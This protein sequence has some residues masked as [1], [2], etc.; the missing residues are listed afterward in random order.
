GPGDRDAERVWGANMTIRSAALERVGPFD[1][2]ADLYGDEEEWQARL[3]AA[4]G[5][6][7]YVAAG[8]LEHR[9]ARPDTTLRALT[10]AAR[11]RG[12]NSRRFDARRGDPPT[13]ARELRVLA[14][15]LWH[16]ARRGCG[17]GLVM[18]AHSAG[19]VA[20]AL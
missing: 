1:A 16:A 20:E 4:G 19:R 18:A 10:R 11:A 7:R 6:I 15:C 9:R 8:G 14:G 3:R 12:R 17:N 5:R 2:A 13:L